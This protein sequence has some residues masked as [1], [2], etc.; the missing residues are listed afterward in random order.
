VGQPVQ[1]IV[2]ELVEGPTLADRIAQGPIPLDDALPIAKQIADAVEAAHEHGIVHRDLKP[3]N[4]K[5]RPDG[6]VKVLDFGLAKALVPDTASA[7]AGASMSPTITTP[8][9]TQAGMILGTA[10]YMSPEQAR[11]KPVDKRTDIWA[12][13]CVLYE[14]L[15]GRRAFQG[16]DVTVTLARVVEREP[17]WTA[18]SA[19]PPG[20]RALLRRCLEKDPRRRLRDIGEATLAL[21][22]VF[23]IV[24]PGD[25]SGSHEVKSADPPA[26]W[27]RRVR[28]W[29]LGAS[30]G[31]VVTAAVAWVV[32]REAPPQP[33]HLRLAAEPLAP[34]LVSTFHRDIAVSP[35]GRRVAMTTRDDTWRIEIISRGSREPITLVSEGQPFG[36]FFSPDGEWVGFYDQ[37]S[38]E[39]RRVRA[40]GDGRIETICS[41]ETG[42]VRG[43]TWGPDGTIVYGSTYG[44]LWLVT[45]RRAEPERFNE[46]E[47]L[48]VAGGMGYHY[49]PSF[50]PNGEAVL[51]TVITPGST[52]MEL[53]MV[54]LETQE[55]TRLGIAGSAPR[56]DEPFILPVSV[57]AAR[58]TMRGI[59]S[60][61][62]RS[63]SSTPSNVAASSWRSARCQ[64]V[65]MRWS[66]DGCLTGLPAPR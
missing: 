26:S 19:Q 5:L 2:M 64:M 50:L 32:T 59:H 25:G 63:P 12:F 60:R 28:P 44:G 65:R 16:D 21:E 37:K 42:Q 49:W 55:V 15:T 54:S 31:I 22:G 58:S 17:D 11:G 46:P 40:N 47:P 52:T 6:T 7:A 57:T 61:G 51:F 23:D 8:A 18:V 13:G 14:M 30:A 34:L 36:P 53:A 20:V 45:P 41:L 62:S 66:R 3:A 48:T 9:M 33:E 1:A 38:G 56:Y 4:I 29:L 35:D 24:V 27:V 43:A 39:L 10:A